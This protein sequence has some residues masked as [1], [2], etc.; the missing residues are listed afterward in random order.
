MELGDETGCYTIKSAILKLLDIR[1][2]KRYITYRPPWVQI[3]SPAPEFPPYFELIVASRTQFMAFSAGVCGGHEL[4]MYLPVKCCLHSF[5]IGSDSRFKL[6]LHTINL[7]V[8][9]RQITLKATISY[10]HFRYAGESSRIL[11]SMLYH[12]YGV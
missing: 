5:G 6:F 10:S 1:L 9:N 8:K 7:R 11:A 12:K 3:P 2:G 4:N